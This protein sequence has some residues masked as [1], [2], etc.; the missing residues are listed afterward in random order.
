MRVDT[1]IPCIDPGRASPEPA[2]TSSIFSEISDLPDFDRR[3]VLSVRAWQSRRRGGSF[4]PNSAASGYHQTPERRGSPTRIIHSATQMLIFGS[5]RG[6]LLPLIAAAAFAPAAAAGTS[7]QQLLEQEKGLVRKQ[8]RWLLPLEI[9]FRS[10]VQQ[11]P[12]LDDNVRQA[13]QKLLQTAQPIIQRNARALRDIQLIQANLKVLDN[14][15]PDDLGPGQRKILEE[16]IK[17]HRS[18]LSTL[19]K[20]SL[21]PAQLSG[22]PVIRAG[23]IELT[24]RR[25]E[26]ALAILLIHDERPKLRSQYERLA[27]DRQVQSALRELGGQRLGPVEDYDHARWLHR[28]ATYEET[29]FDSHLPLYE[30]NGRL[31]ISCIIG[32]TPATF[33]WKSSSEPI[34]LTSS[35]VE[36]IGLTAGKLTAGKLTAGKDKQQ[37]ILREFDDGRKLMLRPIVIPYLRLGKH[38][39]RDVPAFVLPPDGE[40]IGAQIGGMALPGVSA[41][42]QPER[43]R[44][45]IQPL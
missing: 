13:R 17:R 26:L 40:N 16:Q 23:L 43:F 2:H 15:A 4:L 33:T 5:I 45:V 10:R 7:P 30:D 1:P 36:A 21:S 24:N 6:W 20:Q 34:L 42:A 9:S 28:I 37:F 14:R 18:R 27:N 32:R 25:N 38:V 8:G 22:V 41:E 35:M 31:R 44:L 19:Q 29:V 11:L 3:S 12:K 39:L